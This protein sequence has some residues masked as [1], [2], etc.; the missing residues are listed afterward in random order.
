MGQGVFRVHAVRGRQAV[1]SD[2]G[3]AEQERE[4]DL[5][6]FLDHVGRLAGEGR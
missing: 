3:D 5:E 6:E 2:L 1:R 4:M